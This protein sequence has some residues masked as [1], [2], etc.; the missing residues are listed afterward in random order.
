M[1]E[2]GLQERVLGRVEVNDSDHSGIGN[3]KKLPMLS[4]S[5]PFREVIY[6]EGVLSFADII[7]SVQQLPNHTRVKF[8]AY[9]SNSVI[10]SDSKRHIGRNAF[11]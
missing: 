11:L 1:K 5:I 4:F 7:E 3:W 9:G 6:C 10:S 2:A 8:H